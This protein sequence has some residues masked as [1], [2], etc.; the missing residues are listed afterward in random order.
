MSIEFS[1]KQDK[2]YKTAGKN[3]AKRRACGATGATDERGQRLAP[4]RA[5]AQKA[6]PQPK[7]IPRTSKKGSG[8]KSPADSKGSAF[9]RRR[10]FSAR[11]K[12]AK[13]KQVRFPRAA[14]FP[15]ATPVRRGFLPDARAHASEAARTDQRAFSLVTFP[16]IKSPQR[17]FRFAQQPSLRIKRPARRKTAG[18]DSG[19]CTLWL[20]SF[21]LRLG[22]VT[23]WP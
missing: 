10:P 8:D 14:L 11:A 7:R 21:T 16:A 15:P 20:S 13:E 12:A 23:L 6:P 19:N 3:A 17:S 18:P 1:K 4:R 9:G 5:C 2:V 22:S